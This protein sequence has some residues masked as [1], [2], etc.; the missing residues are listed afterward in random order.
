MKK[1]IRGFL[2]DIEERN[3]NLHS[4]LL[5]EKGEIQGEWYQRPYNSQV[6]HRMYSVTKSLV[7]IAIGMLEEEG[8]LG[9]S[10]RICRYFPEYL[11]P[12]PVHPWLWDTRIEDLLTMR[13]CHSRAAYKQMETKRWTA[14]F[15]QAEPDHC[16][17]TVFS[18]DTS[19]SVVLAAL[20]E[21]LSG[22]ELLSYLRERAFGEIGV[23]DL[24]YILKTP[25]GVSD[26]GSG[27]MCTTGDLAKIGDLCCHFGRFQGR[28]LLPEAYMRKAV[29]RQTGTAL[30]PVADERQGYGYQFWLTRHDGFAMYGMGGQLVLCFPEKELTFVTTG[31]TVGDMAGVQGIY[32]A[33]YKNMDP[34]KGAEAEEGFCQ[35]EAWRDGIFGQREGDVDIRCRENAAGWKWAHIVWQGEQGCL[36]YEN[37]RG[38]WKI[39]FGPFEA[40]GEAS[41][42]F[43]EDDVKSP[44]W[45]VV[46]GRRNGFVL[47]AEQMGEEPGVLWIEAGIRGQEITMHMKHSG[48]P[49]F[50]DYNGFVNGFLCG[51]LCG[52]TERTEGR[53]EIR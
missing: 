52:K 50:C 19:A 1:E 29:M 28:Q 35:V 17:G 14:S 40:A 16:P 3:V 12:A 13:T 38:R 33:F 24:A 49:G 45:A 15:F 10:D 36:E 8:K 5:M 27:L 42:F 6:L 20:A 44:S 34:G 31:Y 32:D 22:R 51:K 7:S 9:L 18:Y 37:R 21:R 2:R 11:P 25:D 30:Q 53:S 26:G 23:S 43:M 46:S 47:R 39:P 48:N 4:F 41:L